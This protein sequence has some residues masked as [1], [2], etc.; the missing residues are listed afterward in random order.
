VRLLQIYNQYRSLFGGEETVVQRI[1]N[2][3]EKNGGRAELIMRSSRG[4]DQSLRGKTRA[5]VSG[6]FNPIAARY[7]ARVVD[8]RR[9][10][11]AH[12]HNLYPLFS[13]SV[14]VA[15]KRAGVPVVMTVHNHFHTCPRADHLLRGEIC[16]RCVGGHEFNCALMNCRGNALESAGYALRSWVAR[17]FRL[18]LDNVSIV[19]ALNL[20]AK[21][22]LMSAGFDSRRVVVIPNMVEIPDEAS[23]PGEGRSAVFSGR[24]SPEKGASTLLE[25]ARMVPQI[26]VR[27][28][29]DGPALDQLRADAPKNATFLGQL[30]ADRVALEYRKASFLVAPSQ[31]YEGCPLVISEAMSHGVPVIASRIGGL[32]ELVDDEVTGLLFEPGNAAELARHMD[33]LWQDPDGRRRMG[34]QGRRKAVREY[35]ESVFWDRLRTVYEVAMSPASLRSRLG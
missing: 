9:P 3:V 4:L 5:F 35:S 14:L 32:P 23:D 8:E 34:E 24:M 15:L 19:I 13:P 31:W 11:V 6:V 20:F 1:A 10:D 29:G 21:K 27:L 2:L 26:P 22:R 18:F 17:R 25:A 33:A 28:M 16:E 7:V 30:P 12:V